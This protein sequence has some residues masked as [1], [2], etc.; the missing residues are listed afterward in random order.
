MK[1]KTVIV[2]RD[3]VRKARFEN[4]QN[5]KIT[6]IRPEAPNRHLRSDLG[7]LESLR[8]FG[9]DCELGHLQRDAKR[10]WIIAGT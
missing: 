1:D 9:C 10:Q 7:S 4:S 3:R 2:I 5:V 6:A 8:L